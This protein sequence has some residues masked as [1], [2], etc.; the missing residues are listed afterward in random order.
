MWSM[1][2]GAGR[3]LEMSDLRDASPSQTAANPEG[4]LVDADIDNDAVCKSQARL[5]VHVDL[6]GRMNSLRSILRRLCGV[7]L[8]VPRVQWPMRVQVT[9]LRGDVLRRVDTY[10]P[11]AEIPLPP[12]TYHVTVTLGNI[13]RRYTMTLASGASCDL[14]LR[15]ARGAA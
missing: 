1:Q 9:D 6:A 13:C 12:G 4:L 3:T 2:E 5:L 10:A 15:L 7:H 14:H 8:E 11:L